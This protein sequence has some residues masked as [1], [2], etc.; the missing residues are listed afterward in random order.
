MWIQQACWGSIA[1]RARAARPYRRVAQPRVRLGHL[2]SRGPGRCRPPFRA[3]GRY[4]LPGQPT[5][6]ESEFLDTQHDCECEAFASVFKNEVIFATRTGAALGRGSA[7]SCMCAWCVC[8]HSK[9]PSGQPS[10]L[11]FQWH[12]TSRRERGEQHLQGPTKPRM[13]SPYGRSPSQDDM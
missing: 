7:P 10:C 6:L 13:R 4:C 9:L 3:A 12:P 2:L 11:E 5:R 1:W 8:T